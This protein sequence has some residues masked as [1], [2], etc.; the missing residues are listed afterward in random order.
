MAPPELTTTSEPEPEPELE[1]LEA[2][3]Q[4]API[5]ESSD[6]LFVESELLGAES[7]HSQTILSQHGP[8]PSEHT[9][10]SDPSPAEPAATSIVRC[11]D[12]SNVTVLR[13]G[14]VLLR[15]ALT[16]AA[17]RR[18][19]DTAFRRGDEG[20]VEGV[21]RGF[22]SWWVGAAASQDGGHSSCTAAD[23]ASPAPLELN[24]ARKNAGRVYD[25]VRS[26][27]GGAS[28]EAVACALHDA[29]RAADT[30]LG[31]IERV[32][33]THLQLWN[34]QPKKGVRIG[35]HRDNWWS[36]GSGEFPVL[37]LSIGAT[38]RFLFKQNEDDEAES[39]LLASGDA[40]IF[41]GPC[42]YVMH[43]VKRIHN[44]DSAPEWLQSPHPLGGGRLNF[45]FRYAPEAFGREGEY[46]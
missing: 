17:Q 33:P 4:P 34:Y 46:R 32:A 40:L 29:A 39:V 16:E 11:L 15:G 3:P 2:Q 22:Q 35:W 9:R 19:V 13:P 26:F 7:E 6:G 43:C 23:A 14:M 42:R 38:C 1:P 44:P 12:C 21:A 25:A 37:S 36:D 20:E 45:T 27:P 28:L 30:T 10:K 18:M 41:G 8:A 24:V 31:A 5:M